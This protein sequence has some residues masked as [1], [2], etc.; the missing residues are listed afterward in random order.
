PDRTAGIGRFSAAGIAIALGVLTLLI[1]LFTPEAPGRSAGGLSTFSTA[2]G[3][4]GIVFELAG[5]FGWHT[6]R[7]ITTLDSLR[8]RGDTRR[9]V[10]VVLAPR[11]DLGAHEIHN[12]LDNVRKGGGLIFSLDGDDARRHSIGVR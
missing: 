10:Q 7:R 2:P 9:S 12:L 6:E 4:A 11:E 1:A 5:R 8:R 3:G